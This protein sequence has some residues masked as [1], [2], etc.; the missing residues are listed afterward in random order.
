M[1][2]GLCNQ[3]TARR[4]EMTIKRLVKAAC[5]IAGIGLL[6][7]AV[8]TT[9]QEGGRGEGGDHRHGHMMNP[10]DRTERLTKA[11][12]L[13]DDQKSKVLSIL[14][15]EQKQM[16]AVRS[17]TNL[18]RDDRWAKIREIRQNTTTQIKGTLNADQAK[19]FSD[20]QQEM[21]ARR[22]QRGKDNKDNT[23][24]PQ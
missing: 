7:G 8:S 21:E 16:E 14:Q 5:A 11:L 23:P 4:D 19:K 18:S 9:A 6:F 15:D 3:E 12:N 20:M 10:E 24:P 17:N 2:H 1:T 22:E 13:S